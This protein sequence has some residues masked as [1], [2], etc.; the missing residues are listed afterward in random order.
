MEARSQEHLIK[1]QV[2]GINLSHDKNR[3]SQKIQSSDIEQFVLKHEESNYL[4]FHSAYQNSVQLI[5]RAD[6]VVAKYE[7]QCGIQVSPI[8][9]KA[10]ASSLLPK[11]EKF[12][13]SQ[14]QE[15]EKVQSDTH[16]QD[17]KLGFGS[18]LTSNNENLLSEQVDHKNIMPSKIAASTVAQHFHRGNTTSEQIQVN[19]GIRGPSGLQ[20]TNLQRHDEKSDQNIQRDIQGTFNQ[21]QIAAK[22]F[23]QNNLDHNSIL[24]K[25][26]DCQRNIVVLREALAVVKADDCYLKN[27]INNFVDP[28]VLEE[29]QKFEE[30]LHNLLMEIEDFKNQNNQIFR[31]SNDRSDNHG[32]LRSGDMKQTGLLKNQQI[33]LESSNQNNLAFDGGS[34]IFADIIQNLTVY[35]KCMTTQSSAS[36]ADKSTQIQ[37]KHQSTIFGHIDK[38]MK[39][40]VIDKVY[41]Y[42]LDSEFSRQFLKCLQGQSKFVKYHVSTLSDLT[43]IIDYKL[44]QLTALATKQRALLSQVSEI[45]YGDLL[46]LIEQSNQIV[47]KLHQEGTFRLQKLEQLKILDSKFIEEIDK[48]LRLEVITFNSEIYLE[49]KRRFE[50]SNNNDLKNDVIQ[51]FAGKYINEKMKLNVWSVFEEGEK[52]FE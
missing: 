16:L 42:Q 2:A 49:F 29:H 15:E 17:I 41:D 18:K 22:T 48:L 7:K 50:S 26:R 30:E 33:N 47:I 1:D 38:A 31:G 37:E 13:V 52:L 3:I 11:P 24:N 34:Q 35:C 4:K 8:E 23:E 20:S 14:R 51:E 45:R 12:N 32:F 25:L 43:A 28:Q 21:M 10:Q 27:H 6:C 40:G 5:R 36:Q 9:V 44:K 39:Q 19:Q 46:S